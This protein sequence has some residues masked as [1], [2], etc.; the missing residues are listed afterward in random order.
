MA[1]YISGVRNLPEQVQKNKDDIED[2]QTA[3]TNL[4]AKI[5]REI[6]DRKDLIEA[7]GNATIIENPTENVK[8]ALTESESNRNFVVFIDGTPKLN[9]DETNIVANEDTAVNGDLVVSGNI[10]G[11]STTISGNIT[12]MGD[13]QVANITANGDIKTASGNIETSLGHVK[14]LALVSTIINVPDGNHAIQV[15][16]KDSSNTNHVLKFDA[17]TLKLTIDGNEVGGKQLYEHNICIA[18]DDS[19]NGYTHIF[20]QIENDDA[21]PINTRA[22]LIDYLYNKGFTSVNQSHIANGFINFLSE[23]Y[24]I[25]GLY[26][27]SVNLFFAGLKAPIGTSTN[28]FGGNIS[29]T[30]LGT[31]TDHVIAN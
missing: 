12:A 6:A 13:L 22:L 23:C 7:S 14:G 15:N 16:C 25:V 17:D 28:I 3:D 9:I 30:F 1:I 2:L 21:T 29:N 19:V 5:D 4:D 18:F 24:S 11:G 26:A 8:V 27:T 31:I 20:L 10:D